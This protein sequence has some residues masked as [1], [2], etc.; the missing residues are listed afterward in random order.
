MGPLTPE[1]ARHLS[2]DVE[3]WAAN[4][5]WRE[6]VDRLSPYPDATLGGH[7]RLALELA[8][9]LTYTGRPRRALR[10]A[11]AAESRLQ[12]VGTAAQ[13]LDVANL[14]GGLCFEL[15]DLATAEDRFADVVERASEAGEDVW[16]ARASN[17][18]GAASVL[19]GRIDRALTLFRLA[20]PAYQRRG[21]HRGLAE[22]YHNLAIA[23]R[24]LGFPREADAHYRRAETQAR[25]AGNARLAAMSRLGRAELALRAGDATLAAAEAGQGLAETEAVGDALG[26]AEALKLL[27]S[28]AMAEG[29]LDVAEERLET[30]LDLARSAPNPL[31][32]AETLLERSALRRARGDEEGAGAD[33]AAAARIRSMVR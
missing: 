26:R 5:R 22:T 2:E 32:E 8:R 17:N 24:D 12:S 33:A 1:R 25:R 31:L 14:V 23:Y 18:L 10:L 20:V 3:R 16:L 4:G 28:I 15:G 6:I 21:D 11:L 19:R 27:G 30:A 29:R 9:A 13:R 7:P